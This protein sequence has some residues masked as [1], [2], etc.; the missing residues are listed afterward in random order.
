[1]TL[2]I[3]QKL[4]W[5]GLEPVMPGSWNPLAF[6]HLTADAYNITSPAT[7]NYNCIAWAAG[8]TSKWWEP[9]PQG[10]YRWPPNVPRELTLDAFILAYRTLGFVQCVDAS[11]ET[12]FVKI[13]LYATKESD[14]SLFPTH[15]AIQ[16]PNG[17]WSS[18]LGPCEDIEHFTL[19]AL[20]SDDYGCAVRFLKRPRD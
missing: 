5:N 20:N 2:G 8:D 6:P 9:D 17:T 7:D 1:M 3:W 13:A 14:G 19:E 11:H 18:K 10:Q 12:G 16:L 4:G 15:V